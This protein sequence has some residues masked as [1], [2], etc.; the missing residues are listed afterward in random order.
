MPVIVTIAVL[1]I[2]FTVTVTVTC[3]VV[4]R[5]KMKHTFELSAG[6]LHVVIYNLC[7]SVDVVLES[8]D[9]EYVLILY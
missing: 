4:I 5:T 2:V 9:N 7:T 8:T 1:T 6:I 3:I